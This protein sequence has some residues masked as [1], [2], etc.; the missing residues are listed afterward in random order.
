MVETT[1]QL[2]AA[3]PKRA[4]IYLRVSTTEQ[5]R[6]A[7]ATEGY[8]IPAQ[9]EACTRRANEL[10]AV[11][12]AEFTDRGESA[13][14]ANRPEL[15]KMLALL[16]GH[17]DI[18]YVIVHKVDR[19]ARNRADDVQ[20]VLGIEKAGARLISVT[21][22]VDD[23]P[24][25]KL[26]HN[27]MADLAEFYSSNLASEILK[28]SVQKARL[29]GTPYKAPV[30]YK[31]VRSF[32][33]GRDIRTVEL[34]D[35]RA[36]LVRQA[37]ELYA[38]GEYSLRQL[39][40]A[41]AD[42][43]LVLVTSKLAHLLR[44]R[45]YLGLVHYRGVEYPGKHPALIGSAVFDR[46]QRILDERME[47]SLKLRRHSHY[48]RGLLTCGQCG[49]RLLY[50]RVSNR[51]GTEF[52]YYICS[53][54]HRLHT[55][56]LPY[57]PVAEVERRIAASWPRWMN[58]GKLDADTVA[59]ELETLIRSENHNSFDRIARAQKRLAKVDKER[60]QLLEMAYAE[61]I[62]LDLLK[63]EQDRVGRECEAAQ[64]ALDG[65]ENGGN[66][67][68]ATYELARGLMER[69]AAA[70]DVAG[71]EA[72]RLLIRAFMD[73][74]EIDAD[75]EQAKLASPWQELKQAAVDANTRS[76]SRPDVDGLARRSALGVGRMTNPEA[77][78]DVRG[79]IMIPLVDLRTRMS[80]PKTRDQLQLT[81][82][83][84]EQA[85]H[86]YQALTYKQCPRQRTKRCIAVGGKTGAYLPI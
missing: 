68:M 12:V 48:L 17:K 39:Q 58:L 64:R 55:C 82:F 77:S 2:D 5:A 7:D 71:P 1:T 65:A 52:D 78:L 50:T 40:A 24:S 73:R 66:D 34:D 42:R 11:V 63:S 27:I 29:G 31:N 22:N 33:G 70:Y 43:G 60:R 72:R 75:E 30:G 14:S 20:I 28:G 23:T 13:R 8:S 26:V 51:H 18:D 41:L 49:K 54:R 9:R 37:F 35:E 76:V 3:T 80:S 81:E 86:S 59:R 62:P 44:D 45:Y 56:D 47:H 69:G 6:A 38:T 57:I 83:A 46:V 74:I 4:I 53:Q 61:A 19:L 84:L 32:D 21:E 67:V 10:E 16:N 79:S 15:Q 85:H 36:S 25:G